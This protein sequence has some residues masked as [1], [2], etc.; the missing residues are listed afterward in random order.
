MPR[1]KNV[2]PSYLL[3]KVNGREPQARVRIAGK[4][5]L[6]GRYGSEESRIRYGELIAKFA[7]GV[8]IDPLAAGSNRGTDADPGPSIA[9]LIVAFLSHAETHYVKNGQPTSEQHCIRSAG[10]SASCTD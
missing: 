7:S 5:F 9:E 8:P 4:E 6:L 2:L 10:R 3:H 1:K